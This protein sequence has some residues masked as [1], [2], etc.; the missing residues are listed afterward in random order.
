M[1]H[2]V[3]LLPTAV[4]A[5][6]LGDRR[7]WSEVVSGVPPVPWRPAGHRWLASPGFPRQPVLSTARIHV[8]TSA[9]AVLTICFDL[10]NGFL[11]MAAIRNKKTVPSATTQQQ[12]D[13][14]VHLYPG[15]SAL[16]GSQ[17]VSSYT[18]GLL[19]SMVL[20]MGTSPSPSQTS[21]Q[22]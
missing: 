20:S 21:G 3:L 10:G 2:E 13:C 9:L 22:S 1:R 4:S 16:R 17:T 15:R 6:H 5:S 7:A 11:C 19:W 8:E 18:E 14:C 12:H